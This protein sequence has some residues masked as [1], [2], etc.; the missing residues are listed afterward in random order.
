M[1]STSNTGKVN[2]SPRII[3]VLVIS[4]AMFFSIGEAKSQQFVDSGD[5]ISSNIASM[6]NL[7]V[8]VQFNFE[9]TPVLEALEV[10]ARHGGLELNYNKRALDKDVAITK[11]L[12]GITLYEAID[13]VSTDAG[14]HFYITKS[15]QMILTPE[16]LPSNTG[17]LRGRVIDAE[18]NETLV[19]AT[20]YITELELG[21]AADAVGEFEMSGIPSGIY[22]LRVTSVG[23]KAYI[24]IIEI[25]ANEDLELV[26]RLEPD[27]AFLDQVVVTG[28][29]IRQRSIPT[30]SVTRI[31]GSSFHETLIQSPERC[32]C[33]S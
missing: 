20:I 28:Y 15:G 5:F 30:G 12:N 2:I 3:V 11:H 6:S 1:K 26:I 16:E 8:L 33:I 14:I 19:G 25:I 22:T 18:S 27:V 10:L 9:K 7:N 13:I 31:E 32:L 29:S 17:T 24:H 4:L 21:R 23:Y